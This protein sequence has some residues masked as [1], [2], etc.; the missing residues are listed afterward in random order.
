[1]AE[2]AVPTRQPLTPDRIFG[3]ALAI[4]DA[5][6]LSALSMR[7]L[8]AS[9]GVEAMAI[10]HHV[11]NKD[12]L[13][14][15]VVDLLLAPAADLPG[16]STWRDGL[17][18]G[19]DTLRD[20]LK[21]HPAAVPLLMDSPL[22]TESSVVWIDRPLTLLTGAGFGEA[23]AV[24]LLQATMALL[25]GWIAFEGAS[26]Q[27]GATPVELPADLASAAPLAAAMADPMNDWSGGFD[28]ALDALL[29]SWARRLP[30]GSKGAGRTGPAARPAG[31]SPWIVEKGGDA[32]KAHK[33]DKAGKK[34]G[35]GKKKP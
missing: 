9:L 16:A 20:T 35:K 1:M 8:G 10:Y 27:R 31:G 12:A 5:D 17:H 33:K 6:G 29:D 13:L 28:Q 30:P 4:I 11:P 7:R 23:D 32:G 14:A 2:T 25:F 24:A 22:G 3:A 21:A 19:A 26:L 15:G 18:A 34:K